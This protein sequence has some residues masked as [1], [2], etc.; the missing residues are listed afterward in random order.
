V[1]STKAQSLCAG[2]APRSFRIIAIS[3]VKSLPGRFASLTT[4]VPYGKRPLGRR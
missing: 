4:I 1:Y 2:S 3:P